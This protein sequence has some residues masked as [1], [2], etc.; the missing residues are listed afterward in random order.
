MEEQ[1][2]HNDIEQDDKIDHHA[3]SSMHVSSRLRSDGTSLSINPALN[4]SMPDMNTSLPSLHIEE[5]ARRRDD[6]EA[7]T[8]LQLNLDDLGADLDNSIS[9]ASLTKFYGY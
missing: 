7:Q 1:N 6:D 3:T 4:Q 2:T 5:Y 8:R 9:A